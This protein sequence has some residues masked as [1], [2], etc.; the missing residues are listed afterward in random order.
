[1]ACLVFAFLLGPFYLKKW[2]IIAGLGFKI[3][4]IISRLFFSFFLFVFLS[5]SFSHYIEMYKSISVLFLLCLRV[6][7]CASTVT[8]LLHARLW[9][10]LMEFKTINRSYG[11]MIWCSIIV[12]RG[13]LCC[14]CPFDWLSKMVVLSDANHVE[15][16]IK[17]G[18][19]GRT[20][21]LTCN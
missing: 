4:Y 13:H 1:M 5:F 15:S 14:F 18:C 2:S 7:G 19:Q 8:H 12:L 16:C 10:P 21:N 20:K 9:S 6:Y 17:S 3:C 11:S